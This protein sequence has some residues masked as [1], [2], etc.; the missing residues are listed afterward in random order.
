MENI[1]DRIVKQRR[2]T[3]HRHGHTQGE[4][5]PAE[6]TV[7]LVPFGS[8]PLLL[9]EIKRKSPSKGDIAAGLDAT[10]QAKLYVDQEI[11]AVSV[12]TEKDFFGGSLQDL[13]RVKT[14]FPHLSV[15][16]KDFLL[17]PEDIRVS[18]RAGADA[19]LL[20]AG[21]LSEEELADLYTL[22]TS[23]GMDVLLEIHSDEDIWKAEKIGPRFTG[24]NARDLTSF[25]VDMLTP[26]RVK[27]SI[28]WDTRVVFES[29]I[30]RFEDA[31][32]AGSAGFDGIL[33]GESVLRQPALA[34]ELKEGFTFG[35]SARGQH[36]SRKNKPDRI[37]RAGHNFWER[38][39][40]RQLRNRRQQPGRRDVSIISRPLIKV[41]GLT[42]R[43][44]VDYAEEAGADLLGFVLAPSPR[45]VSTAFIAELGRR[46][47]LTVGV[48]VGTETERELPSDIRALL[49]EGTLDCIQFHGHEA[50][51]HCY[52]MAFPYYKTIRVQDAGSLAGLKGYHSP[53]VLIDAFSPKAYGGTGTT[54]DTS[55][56]REASRIKPLWLAGGITPENVGGI[57]QD[58]RPEL[59][60]CSSGLECRPGKKDHAKI[61]HFFEEIAHA[62]Q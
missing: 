43:A 29:G 20:I 50:P 8:S 35:L 27:R 52:P 58:L 9:C 4:E 46:K 21:I 18:F 40:E 37:P 26:I 42:N 60:D 49:D 22:S 61:R 3:I 45:Q 38:L 16:R 57:I 15:L 6:R 11:G 5:V 31:V 17:E 24:I 56:A 55:L 41:C 1:R 54:I 10:S 2:G 48:Y 33:V 53:R 25:T 62:V 32:L 30:Q 12:L 23:L 14:A 7:P 47:A 59:I 51:E 44:D 36:N 39:V 13:H 28:T 19:V 34:R